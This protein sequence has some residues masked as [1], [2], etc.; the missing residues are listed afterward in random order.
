MDFPIDAIPIPDHSPKKI[1]KT[2]LDNQGSFR[3][4]LPQTR[5]C[6]ITAYGSSGNS[7]ASQTAHRM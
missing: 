5:T 4:G 3:E 6:R 1:P 7:F 2:P